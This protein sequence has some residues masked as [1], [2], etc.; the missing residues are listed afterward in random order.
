MVSLRE[1]VRRLMA[2]GVVDKI[3]HQRV[4]KLSRD[5]PN[6][7][8]VTLIGRSRAVDYREAVPYFQ[9]RKSRQGQR[10]DLTSG[11]PA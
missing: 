10:T 11:P 5:D 6:F 9:Q 8:A 7:P 2:D 3:S 1:L 4:S